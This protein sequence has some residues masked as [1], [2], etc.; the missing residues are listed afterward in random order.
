M[1]TDGDR[2]LLFGILAVQL[3]LVSHDA[4]VCAIN[5]WDLTKDKP[6]GEILV[7]QNA[8]ATDR[9][10]LLEALV[11]EHLKQHDNDPERSLAAVSARARC[12]RYSSRLLVRTSGVPV[13]STDRLL[14]E[15]FEKDLKTKFNGYG[16]S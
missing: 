7:E 15:D 11:Q 3:D 16:P 9:R 8:L 1:E 6:L 14:A 2:N 4:L 5:A 12:G 10:T 13:V